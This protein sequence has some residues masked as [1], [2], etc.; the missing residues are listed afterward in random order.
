MAA[1]T[2]TPPAAGA[3]PKAGPPAQTAAG[4]QARI[5]VPAT[6]PDDRRSLA[7]RLQRSLATT[8]RRLRGAGAALGVLVVVFGLVAGL[9]MNQRAR[10]ADR[11]ATYSG[12][13][14][15]DAAEIYR[16]LADADTTA[17]GGFLLAAE[18]PASVRQRYETDLATASDLLSRAAARTSMSSDAHQAIA[19]L[20]RQ[21]PVYAGLV[22]NARANNRRGYPLGGAYLRYASAL[23]Q[24]T[25]LV[26]AQRL[27]DS[28]TRRLD[29]DHADAKAFPWA[30]AVLGGLVLG[31]LVW[32]QFALF[33]RTNRVV[34]LGLAGATA[35]MLAGVVWLLV[36]ATS[37]AAS[38]SDSRSRGSAPLRALDQARFD[39]LQ[40]HAAEN[41]NLVARGASTIYAADWGTEVA[42]L[43]KGGGP[44]GKG[45][46]PGSLARAEAL[47][48]GDTTGLLREARAQFDLWQKRHEDATALEGKG[49]YDA[50][51]KLTVDASGGA[52]SD[53]AF[54]A[55]DQR[56]NDAAQIQKAEFARAVRGVD[57]DLKTAAIGIAVLALPALYGVV[58][59]IGRRLAEYR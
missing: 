34:N 55:M 44:D 12:P 30:S 58:R 26:D 48:P 8:P 46:G 41:L 23:M 37:S 36:A 50:A 16:S 6:G 7:Q 49:D 45:A 18:E 43:T 3:A 40:A 27:V 52:T 35:A 1:S 19:A 57:G 17:A 54:T 9:Q 2:V 42:A 53:A 33:R 28:E 29:A 15:Q 38:L 51:L 47:S 10:A 5:P 59:G 24:D 31:A 25:M 11:V 32:C 14:S 39:A 21:L 56:L 22:E 20:N 13:L 4:A